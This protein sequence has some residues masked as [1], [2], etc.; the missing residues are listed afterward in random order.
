MR[1]L[2]LEYHVEKVLQK[3]KHFS[4]K[5]F[6]SLFHQNQSSV[7]DFTIKDKWSK[8]NNEMHDNLYQMNESQERLF[9]LMQLHIFF[10][11]N[12]HHALKYVYI[13]WRKS[14]WGIPSKKMW[15][16]KNVVDT[17]DAFV[18]QELKVMKRKSQRN[19]WQESSRGLQGKQ[20]KSKSKNISSFASE[21]EKR[22]E[23][24]V[25]LYNLYV[26]NILCFLWFSCHEIFVNKE[27][28][29]YERIWCR[30]RT[31]LRETYTKIQSEIERRRKRSRVSL[32]MQIRDVLFARGWCLVRVKAQSWHV[33]FRLDLK[34]FPCLW[35]KNHAKQKKREETKTVSG[36]T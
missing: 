1:D 34:R 5:K 10:C 33:S 31:R 26:L 20:P 9:C 16:V 13:S 29:Y 32:E 17:Q 28:V 6:R 8:K 4:F 30:D 23:W 36:T 15:R 35:I 21:G 18:W 19:D 14:L 12:T 24:I 22:K 2:N 25:I 3:A 27:P 7:P 11:L